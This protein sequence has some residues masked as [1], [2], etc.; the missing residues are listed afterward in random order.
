MKLSIMYFL[1]LSITLTGCKSEVD[2][3]VDAQIDGWIAQKERSAKEMESQNPQ[4]PI[5][6]FIKN[7][8]NAEDKRTKPE[9]EAEARCKCLRISGGK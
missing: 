5:S 4:Q 6:E 8:S 2:K 7:L 9:G 3:C 1:M